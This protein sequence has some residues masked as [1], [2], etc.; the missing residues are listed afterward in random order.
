MNARFAAARVRLHYHAGVLQF[1]DDRLTSNE[2][3]DPFWEVI[4]NEEWQNVSLDMK[5]ALDRR[6]SNGRDAALY[7]LKALESAIKIVSDKNG[8]TRG[9]ERGA[10]NFI[11]N[12]VSAS[13]GRFIEP[14]EA[15]MLKALFSRVRNPHGHGPG[16]EAMP[17]LSLVQQTWVIESAMS[18][19]KSLLH[20]SK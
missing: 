3:N 2:I 20:R 17:D 4:R 7:A 16:N 10:A 11:D 18:W 13:N 1:S 19:T 12:L 9:S 6:D 8:W 5:E 14:W 15:E